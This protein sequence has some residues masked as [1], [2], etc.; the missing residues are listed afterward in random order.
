MHRLLNLFLLD[1]W[2][3]QIWQRGTN[4]YRQLTPQGDVNEKKTCSAGMLSCHL[5]NS[6][7]SKSFCNL[8]SCSEEERLTS[9][10]IDGLE[11]DGIVK[12]RSL[13]L[14]S[15]STISCKPKET[16]KVCYWRNAGLH[17]KQWFWNCEVGLLCGTSTTF[18][19]FF[20]KSATELGISNKVWKPLR[21]ALYTVRNSLIFVA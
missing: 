3:T 21:T 10:Y 6:Y 19:F 12:E 15:L 11:R 14:P 20:F 7:L 8:Q 1:F 13:L 4:T 17:L 5:L 16:E 9:W 2:K 18:F